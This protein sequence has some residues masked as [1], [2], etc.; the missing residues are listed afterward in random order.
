MRHFLFAGLMSAMLVAPL[1]TSMRADDRHDRDDQKHERDRDG[2]YYDPYRGDYHAW[3]AQEDQAYRRYLEERHQS[4]R[5]YDRLN[6]K[7]Q[8]DYWKWR[9]SHPDSD[10]RR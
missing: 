10:D 5:E 9:H 3:N 7:D 4:Y 2:R 6:K 8:R 1:T